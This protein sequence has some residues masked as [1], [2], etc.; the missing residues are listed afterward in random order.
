MGYDC[1]F[2]LVDEKLITEELV[3]ALLGRRDPPRDLQGHYEDHAEIWQKV[4]ASLRDDPPEAAA[5]TICQLAVMLASCRLP[6]TQA[7]GLAF[8]LWHK[9]EA[10]AAQPPSGSPAP[11]FEALTAAHPR[12]SG[13]FPSG[14]SS[15]YTTG[16]YLSP[17]RVPA[18]LKWLEGQLAKIAKGDR[19]Q[20]LP[21]VRVLRAAA[22]GGYGFWE[23]TDLSVVLTGQ[24]LLTEGER[25]PAAVR[26][27]SLSIYIFPTLLWLGEDALLLSEDKH[28]QTLYLD[29][30]VFPPRSRLRKGEF[31]IGAARS[32][33]GRWA[34]LASVDAEARPRVFDLRFV[35]ELG[36]EARRVAAEDRSLDHLAASV[37]DR[38]YVFPSSDGVRYK[39]TFHPWWSDGGP[40]QVDEGLPAAV[41]VEIGKLG[42]SFTHG[43]V[44]LG[45][46]GD[47]LIWDGNG[48]ERRGEGWEATFA[49]AA[50]PS[51][52]RWSS[53]PAGSDGFY[54]LSNRQLFEVHRGGAPIRHLPT[55]DNVMGIAPGPGGS[56]ILVEGQNK[57]GDVAKVYFPAEGRY[58]GLDREDFGA[59][60]SKGFRAV[61]WSRAAG[62][63]LGLHY[64]TLR[65][66]PEAEVL[67]K[68]RTKPR[69]PKR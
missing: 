28:Y 51:H 15:N 30:S 40:L 18:A 33:G 4:R 20:Y 26:A 6:H 58:T 21:I 68:K 24:A 17:A 16:V 43:S 67:A 60:E 47:V 22:K 37:G 63:V 57:Q 27:H 52:V 49:I 64:D 66:L 12:L 19:E 61:V 42:P 36:G 9:Q 13:R 35:D 1:T 34:L 56:L 54:Y 65:A 14:F 59:S 32:R 46:G 39:K 11:L 38:V 45:D 7:R 55:M 53:V 25:K 29:L 44:Q 10:I 3:P 48:Y 69:A 23:A 5:Q 31:A 62:L 41:G 50:Q 8:S 2:H